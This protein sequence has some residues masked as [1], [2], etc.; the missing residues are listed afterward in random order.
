MTRAVTIHT[1]PHP[2][3]LADGTALILDGRTGRVLVD[4]DEATIEDYTRRRVDHQ[5][6]DRQLLR[7]VPLPA[8]TRDGRP[9]TAASA[10][11]GCSTRIFSIS[12]G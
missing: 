2:F 6:L 8:E 12:A 5:A 3:P 4:P 10:T 1:G 11:A 7:Y 9:T